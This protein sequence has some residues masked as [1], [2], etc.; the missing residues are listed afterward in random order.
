M[1]NPRSDVLK[2]SDNVTSH[3]KMSEESLW[4]VFLHCGGHSFKRCFKES[5]TTIVHKRCTVLNKIQWRRSF[6]S[7]RKMQQIKLTSG[8]QIWRDLSVT[9]IMIDLTDG[10]DQHTWNVIG[11]ILHTGDFLA[12]TNFSNPNWTAKPI[13]YGSKAA[14]AAGPVHGHTTPKLIAGNTTPNAT[15]IIIDTR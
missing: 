4:D 2:Q 6:Q 11:T 7:K 12:M 14:A 13:R 3:G 1:L 9:I 5:S 10:C 8:W 15:E